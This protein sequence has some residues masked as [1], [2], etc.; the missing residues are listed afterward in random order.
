[1]APEEK[2]KIIKFLTKI[3]I[4]L[5][6]NTVITL[7]SMSLFNY[8]AISKQHSLDDVIKN[9]NVLLTFLEPGKSAIK[10]SVC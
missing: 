9:R 10:A 8:T 1:M 2:F 6:C 3:K 5:Q 4:E 7:L